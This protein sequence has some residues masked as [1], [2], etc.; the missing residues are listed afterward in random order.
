MTT[1]RNPGFLLALLIAAVHLPAQEVE[2]VDVHALTRRF[3]SAALESAQRDELAEALLAEGERGAKPLF[4]AVRVGLGTRGRAYRKDLARHLRDFGRAAPVV[5]RRRLGRQGPKRVEE[6]RDEVLGFSRA[7]DLSKDAVYREVDP[8]IEELAGLLRITP[9]QVHEAQPK[10]AAGSAR[11]REESE[12]LLALFG[13]RERAEVVLLR[14]D[15]GRR[16]LE[17]YPLA[18]DPR[19]YL[20][21]LV[22]G[23]A[24]L[25][26]RAT[27]MESRG[28]RVLTDNEETALEIQAEEARGIRELNDIRILVGLP[29]LAID[30]KLCAAARGHSEDMV[31]LGFFSHTS[32]VAGKESFGQRAAL[33]GTSASAENIAAGQQT[34][35]GA[36]RAWW[37]S[38]GH[39]RN[40]MSGASRVGLGRAADRWT[41]M[42]GG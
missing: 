33:A 14:S 5:L 1:S 42:F 32:P 41:Q 23:E 40:M 22:R 3:R 34:G 4:N 24:R 16:Q 37:Y 17:L 9:G 28:L 35:A 7:R 6:L 20:D 30:V 12:R 11:L 26:H 36:I 38:P 27:P 10:L 19:G 25:A 8:R 15:A 18:D 2:P 31:R 29:V 13:F 21:D 39:H